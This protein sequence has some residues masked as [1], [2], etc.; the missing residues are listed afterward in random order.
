MQTTAM[1]L[2]QGKNA[3]LNGKEER[4]AL[5]DLANTVDQKL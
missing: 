2:K 5:S 1:K 3:W 4:M